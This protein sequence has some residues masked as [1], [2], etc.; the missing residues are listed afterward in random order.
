MSARRSERI[1]WACQGERHGSPEEP[2]AHE[3]TGRRETP[4]QTVKIAAR[5]T[6]YLLTSLASVAFGMST[7]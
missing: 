5:Y 2:G 3:R 7:N 1:M 6:R 4:M